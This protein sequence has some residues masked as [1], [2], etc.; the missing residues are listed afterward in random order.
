MK[1]SGD[2]SSV[3]EQRRTRESSGTRGKCAGCSSGGT[4]PFIR[5]GGGD[6]G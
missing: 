4:R 2:S 1:S 5:A 3:R 6:N